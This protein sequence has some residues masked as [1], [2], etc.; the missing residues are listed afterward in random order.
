MAYSKV[1]DN[2]FIGASCFA[3]NQD[4]LQSEKITHILICTEGI[5][6]SFPEDFEYKSIPININKWSEIFKDFKEA[7]AFIKQILTQGNVLVYCSNGRDKSPSI[8]IAYLIEH[9]N[10]TAAKAIELV[11]NARPLISISGFTNDLEEFEKFIAKEK[12]E[13]A[14]SN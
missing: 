3:T 12:T 13:V 5:A 1:F 7:G 14:K 9:M 10:F 6:P 2:L 8:V 11:K 4:A